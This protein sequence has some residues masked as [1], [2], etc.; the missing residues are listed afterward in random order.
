MK[1]CTGKLFLVILIS[2]FLGAC[3]NEKKVEIPTRAALASFTPSNTPTPS[4]T[5]LPT[6]TPTASATPSPTST[7]KIEETSVSVIATTSIPV[8]PSREVI[9]GVLQ[10]SGPFI[11]S[12]W[13]NPGL[14]FEFITRVEAGTTFTFYHQV[15]NY[16][17]ETWYFIELENGTLGWVK[18]DFVAEPVSVDNLDIAGIISATPSFTPSST[19]TPTVTPTHTS[20]MTHTNTSTATS[21]PTFTSTSTSTP[22]NTA[23][24]TPTVTPSSTYTYTPSPTLP[25]NTDGWIRTGLETGAPLR[26][27]PS[28]VFQSITNLPDDT[29]VTIIGTSEDQNWLQVVPYAQ[30]SYIGWVRK[31]YLTFYELPDVPLTWQETPESLRVNLNCGID[32]YRTDPSIWLNM[33]GGFREVEWVRLP[34]SLRKDN[35]ATLEE[36][37]E[38]Y[39]VAVAT[40]NRMGVKTILILNNQT[41]AP[42]SDEESMEEFNQRFLATMEI[43]VQQMGNDI[44]GYQIW[45]NISQAFEPHEYAQL[46]HISGQILHSYDAD[47]R[48]VMGNIDI[49]EISYLDKI[50][51]VYGEQTMADTVTISLSNNLS[52]DISMLPDFMEAYVQISKIPVWLTGIQVEQSDSFADYVTNLTGLIQARYPTKIEAIVVTPWFDGLVDS[53]LRPQQPGFDTFFDICQEPPE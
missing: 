44:G 14:E 47:A 49:E 31:A 20:T 28:V 30:T 6:F 40:Y 43:I 3:Q 9:K 13:T 4:I 17:G 15:L 53:D 38:F 33:P 41:T 42:P 8:V 36:A 22:T 12:L 21:T 19:P 2:F 46:L 18:S 32:F 16:Q 45:E 7:I 5:P 1:F 23:T 39:K 34:V 10:N 48:L 51:Q 29:P 37:L 27:G 26:Q 25:P 11:P 35:F 52:E 24:S 50:F